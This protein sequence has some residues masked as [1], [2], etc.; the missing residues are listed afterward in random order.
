MQLIRATRHRVVAASSTAAR[1][2]VAEDAGQTIVLFTAAMLGLVGMM[3]IV[4]DVAIRSEERRQLQN[5]ADAAALAAVSLLPSDPA[6]AEL[7]AI[8]YLDKNGVDVTDPNV[9]YNFEWPVDGN[10]NQ[11]A[12]TVVRERSTLFAGAFGIDKMRPDATA[13]AERIT[14][15]VGYAL[16]ATGT[17][18]GGADE[19]NVGGTSATV[20]GGVHSNATSMASGSWH[21]ITGPT[22]YVC[23][24]QDNGNTSVYTPAPRPDEVTASPVNLSYVDFACNF[25]FSGSVNLNTEASVWLNGDPNT[26]VL[27]PG[28]YCSTGDLQLSGSNVSGH[29]TFV[30]QGRVTISGSDFDLTAYANDVLAL[31]ES[32]ASN[33]LDVSGSGGSWTGMLLAPNGGAQ[34]QGSD[35]LGISGGVI[36]DSILVGGSNFTLDA[37]GFGDISSAVRIVG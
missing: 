5:A 7:L 30:A 23:T 28:V 29:V 17:D 1:R 18:C 10:P 9:S 11:A 34:L 24:F 4:I 8:T 36:A 3:A 37:T 27:L 22:T 25:P 35:N 12:V 21:S 14:P 16:L 19:I 13:I 20:I 33:S 15:E 31:S 6:G 32:S 2:V 26:G